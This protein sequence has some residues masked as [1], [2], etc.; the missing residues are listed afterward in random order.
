MKVNTDEY[1]KKTALVTGGSKG[2]GREV[3]KLLAK[4]NI[5]VIFTYNKNYKAAYALMEELKDCNVFITGI[6]CDL[7]NQSEIDHLVT[8]ILYTY[9]NLHFLVNNAGT[10]IDKPFSQIK[11]DDWH[12]VIQVNLNATAYL[13]QKL[14]RRIL[15]QQGSV[16]NVT[17]ISGITGAIGQTNYSA[18]KA[19]IIGF[20]RSLAKE[21][22]T[23]NVR[24]N[25]V[26][27]GYI[28]TE[29]LDSVPSTNIKRIKKQTALKRLGN[30]KEIAETIL[31]LLSDK[32]SYITG[33]TLIVDGGLI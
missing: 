18:A 24:V 28:E 17:S 4:N 2:I 19:G 21:V 32:A 31:F 8:T 26:A 10:N 20:T 11:D 27:P 25:C 7:N 6:P 13:T 12:N 3:V 1:Q 22:G 9:P 23:F 33:Q 29:M 15:I 14:L 16:V 5:N 30:K